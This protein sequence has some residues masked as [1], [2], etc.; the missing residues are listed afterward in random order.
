MRKTT[1]KHCILNFSKRLTLTGTPT[2]RKKLNVFFISIFTKCK[3]FHS[4]TCVRFFMLLS[5]KSTARHGAQCKHI[6]QT[7]LVCLL[8]ICFPFF[9]FPFFFQL[10]IV[11]LIKANRMMITN[12]QQILLAVSVE[13]NFIIRQADK[14]CINPPPPLYL[15]LSPDFNFSSSS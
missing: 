6:V 4:E 9:P 12:V 8:H 15:F 10:Q 13:I 11:Q 3:F 7:R 5:Q 1:T 2:Y 14:P